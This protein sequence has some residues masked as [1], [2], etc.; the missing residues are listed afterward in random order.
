MSVNYGDFIDIENKFSSGK[1]SKTGTS[2]PKV[3]MWDRMSATWVSLLGRSIIVIL[4]SY[5]KNSHLVTLP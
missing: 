3:L 1:K 5:N 4:N 2:S